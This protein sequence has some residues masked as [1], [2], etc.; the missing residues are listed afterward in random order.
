MSHIR[1]AN[2]ARK[3]YCEPWAILP[4]MHARIVEI[5]QKRLDGMPSDFEMPDCECEDARAFDV[6]DGVAIIPIKGVISKEISDMER[7]SGAVDLE[8]TE[9]ML[10]EALVRDDVQAIVLRIN[11]PG[12]TI[13]GVPEMADLIAQATQK[14]AV[15]AFADGLMA[16]AAYWLACGASAI[17]AGKSSEVGSIGV[18]IAMLDESKAYEMAGEKREL[19]KSSDTPYKAAGYPGT[20]LTPDQRKQLQEQVDYLFGQFSSAI[21]ASRAVSSDAMQGQTFFGDQAVS[22]GL[23]DSVSTIAQAIQDAKRIGSIIRNQ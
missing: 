18:Y 22:V 6:I 16:S 5:F 19:I 17:Y 11:S 9:A 7:M 4:Q 8:D 1:F 12:G 2:C 3:L 21:T 13:S 15:V 23:V 14:K 10:S 20:S